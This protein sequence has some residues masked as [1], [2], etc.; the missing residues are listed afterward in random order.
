MKL[1]DVSVDRPVFAVMM[2]VALIVLGAFSYRHL[3]LDLMP[4]TDYPTVMVMT[5]LPGAS[6]EEVESQITKRIESVVNSINGVDELRGG[7][8]DD[9]GRTLPG[10]GES[11][12]AAEP[13]AG[14]GDDRALTGEEAHP[15]ATASRCLTK[16][17]RAGTAFQ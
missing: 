9:D 3:G 5:Q 8:V 6:A 2:S 12:G 10:E 7:A 4:K 1:A 15:T 17:S 14:T 11:I 16:S 13:P